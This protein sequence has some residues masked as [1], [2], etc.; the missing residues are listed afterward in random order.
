MSF[1]DNTKVA[2]WGLFIVGILLIIAAIMKIVDGAT[3]DG[4]LGENLSFVVAGIGSLIAAFVYFGFGNSVRKGEVSKKIDVLGKFVRTYGVATVI[5]GFFGAIA[6]LWGEA[7]S[8]WDNIVILIIG[9]IVIWIASKINDGKT[10]NFDK[11]LWIILLIVFV[12]LFILTL[13]DINFDNIISGIANVIMAIVY[14]Y[15][16]AFLFD[17]DVRKHMGM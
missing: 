8:T 11:I 6:G 13:L 5:T 10:T 17:G 7:I 3:A 14:L 15:M 9:L 16:I 1:F 2:G 12:V 4:G